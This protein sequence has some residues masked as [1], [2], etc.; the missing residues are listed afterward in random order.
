MDEFE[1]DNKLKV[2]GVADNEQNSLTVAVQLPVG[3]FSDPPEFE[4]L[5]ELTANL[6]TKGTESV[7]A[8]AFAEKCENAGATIFADV[9]EEYCVLGIR[10]RAPS[11]SSLLPLFAEMMDRPRLVDEEFVRLQR[12]MITSFK[13]EAVDPHGLA[14]RHFYAELAGYKHPA[15]RLETVRSLKKITL[16]NVRSFSKDYFS[17]E[18]ALCI[19]AGDLAMPALK[20]LAT[21]HFSSWRR[22]S[23]KRA[24]IAPSLRLQPAAVRL[25]DKKDL[26]QASF[27]VGHACPGEKCP[28]KNALLLANHIFGG[29]N[30]SSRLMARIRSAAGKTYGISSQLS[31]ETDFGA[32]MIATSTQNRDLGEV[33]SGVLEEYR[34]FCKEGV[35]AEELDKAKK[36]AIGN[37]AFQLEGIGNVV[38]KLLWLR[39][40]GRPNSYI[41]KFEETISPLDTAAVNDAIHRHLSP[42]NLIVAA[43]GKRAA[44]EPQLTRFGAVKHYHF[45]SKA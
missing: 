38:D 12:E 22:A 15:G 29:G 40:Y 27:V 18:G 3:R 44:I 28:E 41:E 32:F 26:T 4:G 39:F 43:V 2:I 23:G 33:L 42:D 36:F 1:L 11:A 34:R 30:F 10:M 35:T 24:A 9:G 14:T 16:R 45:R 6:F 7:P 8:D 25:I 21:A 37:M 20:E 5:C 31:T 13:A 19:L 17:P